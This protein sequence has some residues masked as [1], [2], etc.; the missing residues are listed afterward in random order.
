[1]SS[2]STNMGMTIPDVNDDVTDTISD[3]ATDLT[4]LDG[5]WPVG[6]IYMSTVSTDPSTFLGGT[7]SRI[8]GRFL[9]GAS[10]T[11]PAGSTGGAA[12]HYHEKATAG[13]P[14]PAISQS[15]GGAG[16]YVIGR[17]NYS[18]TSS[19]LPP[20]LAVYVWERTA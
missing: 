12:T 3:L 16:N 11:Y 17:G 5:I 18:G 7:W 9:L 10:S 1:M 4:W 15:P 2:T 20:Y 13:S 19:S 14:A 8:Q 6:S